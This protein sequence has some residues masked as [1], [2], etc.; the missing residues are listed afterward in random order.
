MEEV[1]NHSV[2][3]WPSSYAMRTIL[4]AFIVASYCR[5]SSPRRASGLAKMRLYEPCLNPVETWQTIYNNS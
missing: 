5:G 4:R 2:M 3:T 1:T